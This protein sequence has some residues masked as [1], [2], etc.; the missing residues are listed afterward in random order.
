MK[1]AALAALVSLAGCGWLVKHPPA[2]AAVTGVVLG[3]AT[4]EIDSAPIA[5]CG[6]IAGIAGAALG[7]IAL[8]VTLLTN[9]NAAPEPEQAPP[10]RGPRIVPL[11]PPPLDA[12]VEPVPDAAPAPPPPVVDAGVDA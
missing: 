1:A 12:G 4:C 9:T 3:F 5:T 8:L 10:R 7:G 6:E 2:A 11:P